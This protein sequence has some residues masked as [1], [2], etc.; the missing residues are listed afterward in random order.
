LEPLQPHG[1]PRRPGPVLL[2]RAAPRSAHGLG[3]GPGDDAGGL[4][5]GPRTVRGDVRPRRVRPVGWEHVPGA[6]RGERRGPLRAPGDRDGPPTSR[7]RWPAEARRF[8]A[9]EVSATSTGPRRGRLGL[10]PDEFS[11]PAS[12]APAPRGGRG[13]GPPVRGLAAAARP[14]RRGWTPQRPG[15]R[16]GRAAA[17]RASVATRLAKHVAP[18]R[19]AGPADPARRLH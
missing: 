13:R 15:A 16:P 1:A 4:P 12:G 14:P 5:P 2:Q 19:R 10:A 7:A 11:R 17:P 6:R 3:G 8:S 18:A 9:D